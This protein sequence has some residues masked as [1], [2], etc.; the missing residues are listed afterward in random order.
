MPSKTFKP[1]QEVPRSGQYEEVGPRGAGS[2]QEVTSVKGER[3]PPTRKP[4]NKF[5]L[6]DPTKHK[7]GK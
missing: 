2:G 7:K 5:R 1:G 6:A 4:G 3:F